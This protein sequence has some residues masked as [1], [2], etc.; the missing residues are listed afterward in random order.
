MV[1]NAKV[2]ECV[3]KLLD[4]VDTAARAWTCAM[5]GHLAGHGLLS[6]VGLALDL[7]RRLVSLLSDRDVTVRRYS[8]YALCKVGQSADGLRVVTE[9]GVAHS[10]LQFLD[11]RDSETQEWTC[12]MLGQLAINTCASVLL[13]GHKACPQL[14]SL[15]PS[16]SICCRRNAM[17]ALSKI[18][19]WHPTAAA[20]VKADVLGFYRLTDCLYSADDET[21]RLTC[22]MLGQLGNYKGTLAAVI[23]SRPVLPL[24]FLLRDDTAETVRASAVFALARMCQSVKGVARMVKRRIL[25]LTRARQTMGGDSNVPDTDVFQYVGKLI[26]SQDPDVRANICLLLVSLAR[27]N[28]PLTPARRS[29]CPCKICRRTRDADQQSRESEAVYDVSL[30]CYCVIG[31]ITQTRPV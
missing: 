18:T 24:L 31:N 27:C 3:P 15:L 13:L 20:A 21:R 23:R 29:A 30:R 19:E 12:L 25:Y 11:S 7:P 5:L 14:V 4:S 8:M 10:V 22:Q 9:A 2:M 1:L 26:E 6:L 16:S 28:K 17:F